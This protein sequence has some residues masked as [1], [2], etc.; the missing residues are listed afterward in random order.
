MKTDM[1][2]E[3]AKVSILKGKRGSE[4]KEGTGESESWGLVGRVWR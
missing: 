4:R 1:F 2:W 3:R